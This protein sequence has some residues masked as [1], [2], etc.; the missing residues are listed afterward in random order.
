MIRIPKNIVAFSKGKTE[1]YEAWADYVSHHRAEFL[2]KKVDYDKSMT[3]AEKTTRLNKA[4][5]E[6]IGKVAGVTNSGILSDNMWVTHPTYRWATF[7][8]ISAMVDMILPETII[9]DFGN[10]ADVRIGGYGDSFAFDIHP[11]DLFITTKLSH[12]KRNSFAQ[13]QYSNQVTVVPETRAITVEEDLYRILANKVNLAEWA[14]KC[15][16]SL[17]TEISIDVYNAIFTTYGSLLANFQTAGYSVNGFSALAQRVTAANFGATSSCF[18]TKLALSN[19]L[20]GNDFLKMELGE[21]Y[22]KAGYVNS[23]FG[24]DL[25]EIPQRINWEAGDYSF[26]ISDNYLYF[27]S[28]GAQRLVK[29]CL[30]GEMLNIQDQAF[31]NANLTQTSTFLKKY[32]VAIASNAHYGILAL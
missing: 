6:E 23:F 29:I 21:I 10:F 31:N 8:V 9:E 7:A 1:L 4:I 22:S 24:V 19:V 28:T 25:Y 20:P 3:F 2:G 13:R 11:N 16:R 32:G 26:N 18:G 27:I 15:V 5:N 30:E 17:E 12:G 14:M